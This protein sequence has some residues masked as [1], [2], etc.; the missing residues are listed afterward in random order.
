VKVRIASTSVFLG[1]V[2]GD[3]GAGGVEFVG[4]LL[5]AGEGSGYV[6][7]VADEE[8]GGVDEY[9]AVGVFGLDLE[10][11]EDGFGEGL[12]DGQDFGGV[13]GG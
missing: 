3:G 13:G 6:V 5:G 1:G 2:E 4:P 10:A 7:G 12:A 8:V 11:V 9:G